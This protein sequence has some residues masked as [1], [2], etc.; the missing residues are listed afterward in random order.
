M[1]LALSFPPTNESLLAWVALV[2]L[3]VVLSH[4]T[5]TLRSWAGVYLGGVVFHLWVLDWIRTLYGG[6][7]LHG[8]Y[9]PGWLLSGQIGA[10]L[11]CLMV[12]AGRCGVRHA[13]LPVTIVLP[14]VWM[15]YEYLQSYATAFFDQTG[16]LLVSLA[17][18]QT[19]H[20]TV[21]QL[22]S[23]GGTGLISLVVVAT[24]GFCYDALCWIVTAKKATRQQT[25]VLRLASVPL[26]LVAVFV[27]GQVSLLQ[28][29]FGQ[30]PT[31]SL[32]GHGDLPPLLDKNRIRSESPSLVA[33]SGFIGPDLLVW[34]ELAYHHVLVP[35]QGSPRQLARLNEACPLANG[36][37]PAYSHTVR[38]YL[39]QAAKNLQA[40]LLIGCERLVS[41]D[42]ELLRYNCLAYVDP[43]DGSIDHYDKCHLAP[44][45]EFSPSCARWLPIASRKSFARGLKTT[46]FVL[47]TNQSE[48]EY[49]L[50]CGLCYDVAFAKHFLEQM[51]SGDVDFFVISGSE[52]AD[53]TGCMS[54]MLLSMAQLRAIETRRPMIRNTH[55]GF[56]GLIDANGR[57]VDRNHREKLSEPW[58]LGAVPL[59]RRVSLYSQMGDWLSP[60][61]LGALLILLIRPKW[62]VVQYAS[63]RSRQTFEQQ[64]PPTLPTTFPARFATKG[65]QAFSLLEL[66]A[67]V[68]IIGTIA[69]LVIPRITVSTD[70]A[71][72]A[73]DDLNRAQIN[74][75]VERWYI[76]TNAWPA[77]DLSDIGADTDYFPDGVPSNPVND[78]P[79][80][81]NAT[82]HRVVDWGGG[83][84]K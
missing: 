24:N 3:G 28:K 41:C 43:V 77:N 1:L 2:P 34:S 76:E 70:A 7:G 64:R 25:H 13:K 66:L 44:F 59:D 75:L 20:A 71:N 8:S 31:V 45:T 38:Q 47:R 73:M 81:L 27:Y 50:G 65:R 9:V 79:Y 82:T 30:G 83:G 69:A 4:P 10:L 48:Q 29:S 60:T 84:G 54:E 19:D 16:A 40:G 57:V 72:E 15:S 51:Q 14:L 36:D 62:N 67:V 37:V 68:T 46:P 52:V 22:A 53:A 32:M 6:V 23:L 17:Y 63:R 61:C 5:M 78:L 56:S 26:A 42:N 49:R 80:L 55:L 21:A 33:T 11:F 18:T 74:A 39:E 35:A 12:A 58:Q